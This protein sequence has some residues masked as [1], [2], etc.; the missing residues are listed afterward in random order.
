MAETE[1]K[2]KFNHRP[3]EER[4]IEIDEKIARHK[5]AIAKLETKKHEILNPKRR[6]SKAASLK[7]IISK[8]KEA[9]MSNEEIAEKLGISL[10]DKPTANDSVTDNPI[11]NDTVTDDSSTKE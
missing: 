10:T 11:V 9:G 1:T 6:A 8:A 3:T 2:R 4:I 5:D 7:A